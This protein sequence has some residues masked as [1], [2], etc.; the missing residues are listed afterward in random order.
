MHVQIFQTADEFLT[1]TQTF[2]EQDEGINNLL[3]GSAL[4]LARLPAAQQRTVF[5]GAVCEGDE[6]LIA[7]LITDP[8]MRIIL[9]GNRAEYGLAAEL[10]ARNGFPS[11]ADLPGCDGPVAV[12]RAFAMAWATVTGQTCQV[13]MN[14]RAYSLYRVTP[15]QNSAAGQMQA[16]TRQHIDLVAGWV[17]AFQDEAS[18]E[19]TR[20]GAYAIAEAR[21]AGGDVFLWIVDGQPVSMAARTRPG[22]RSIGINLVYTPPEQRGHGYATACVVA[23]SQLMLDSGYALCT[24]YTDLAN[25]TS[26]S[27]Y[28]KMGYQPVGDLT[29]YYFE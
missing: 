8:R 21:I 13:S 17:Y 24:L 25:A 3:L 14:M 12:S 20:E 4:R 7:A 15:P 10:L 6:L 29:Q 2:L 28:Q 26:N 18:E 23:L 19:P 5:Y 16:A 9:Y 11:H 22:K 27:I 1:R